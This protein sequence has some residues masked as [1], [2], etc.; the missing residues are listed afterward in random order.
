MPDLVGRGADQCCL[1]KEFWCD[2]CTKLQETTLCGNLAVNNGYAR[3][4]VEEQERLHPQ[5]VVFWKHQTRASK[6][7]ISTVCTNERY[8]KSILVTHPRI[9]SWPASRIPELTWRQLLTQIPPNTHKNR[10]PANSRQ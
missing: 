3:A 4:T 6:L 5:H 2:V 9:I 8:S 1:Q 7:A 10:E